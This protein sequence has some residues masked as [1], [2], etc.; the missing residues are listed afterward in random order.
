MANITSGVKHLTLQAC[1][2][3]RSV[4]ASADEQWGVSRGALAAG[5]PSIL[6]PMWNV[7]LLSSS[8]TSECFYDYWQGRSM[9]KWTALT[10]AQRDT[11]AAAPSWS[12]PYHWAAFKLI[13]L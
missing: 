12:H 4:V 7:D 10:M 3:G 2:L 9:P 11:S 6:A 1:S 13:G 5:I 8:F